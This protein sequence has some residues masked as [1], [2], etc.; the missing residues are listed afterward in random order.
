MIITD[1]SGYNKNNYISG[2][3]S[4]AQGTVVYPAASTMTYDPLYQGV[5]KLPQFCSGCGKPLMILSR[6]LRYTYDLYNGYPIS[7]AY[8]YG[9]PTL[10][11]VLR[12]FPF[13][14]IFIVG[15]SDRDGIRRKLLWNHYLIWRSE[16]IDYED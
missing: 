3:L 15:R 11:K 9:C 1:K 16:Q 2:S 6:R 14:H 7:K 4:F 8:L 12:I 10:R 13:V 5:V